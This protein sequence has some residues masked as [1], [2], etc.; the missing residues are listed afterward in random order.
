MKVNADWMLEAVAEKSLGHPVLVVDDDVLVRSMIADVLR[1][2]ELA[3]IE[4]GDADEALEVLQSG[5]EVALLFSDIRMPGSMDGIGLAKVVRTQFPELRIILTSAERPP[6]DVLCD[7]F[8]AKPWDI[9]HVIRG[10][11]S[12][13]PVR[14]H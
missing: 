3:V 10:V 1:D 9:S 11:K 2:A 7:A 8:Y 4:C 13:L 14:E 6:R 12:L 5:T